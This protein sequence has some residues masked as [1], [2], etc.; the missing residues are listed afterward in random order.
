M[1]RHEATLAR[2]CP[3]CG[4]GRAVPC[5]W[6]GRKPEKFDRPHPAR[7]EETPERKTRRVLFEFDPANVPDFAP[8]QKKW[9]PEFSLREKCRACKAPPGVPCYR[10][11]EP[12]ERRASQPHFVRTGDARRAFENTEKAEKA[13]RYA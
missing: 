8:P 11:G 12:S 6:P 3:T 1:K 2:R 5:Y 7:L 9:R 13:K 4:M 10:R